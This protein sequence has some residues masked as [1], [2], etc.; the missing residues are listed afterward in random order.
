[1]SE[2]RARNSQP[3]DRD[4]LLLLAVVLGVLALCVGKA[5]TVDAPL[6]L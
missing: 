3:V 4:L 6:F 1:M 5:F 2:A